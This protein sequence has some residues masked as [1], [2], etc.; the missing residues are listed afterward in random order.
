MRVVLRFGLYEGC[1]IDWL[2][3]GCAED[4]MD[5]ESYL[6]EGKVCE[7]ENPG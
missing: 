4:V 6:C 1:G 3:R 2:N 5:A 7:K